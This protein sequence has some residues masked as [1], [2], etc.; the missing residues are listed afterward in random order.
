MSV[1][2]LILCSAIFVGFLGWCSYRAA[3]LRQ[4]AALAILGGGLVATLIEPMLDN[5]GLLWFARDNVGIAFHLFDRYMPVYVVLGYGFFF[6]G[7]AFL[8]YDGLRKGKP[9]RFLWTLYA[10]AWVFDLAIESVGHRAGLYRYY[11]HQPFN[12][13]GVPLWWMFLNPAL[14]V[15]AGLIF[16]RL[17]DRLR[18]VRS[19]LA[20]PLL[21]IVYGAI[22]GGAGW[23]I[24]MALHSTT[25]QAVL[26]GAA[27]ATDAFALLVVWMSIALLLPA[28]APAPTA[29]LV[30]KV[31]SPV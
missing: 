12:L 28:T 24:F 3:R 10:A 4:P 9:A 1:F 7:Q 29:V 22:Y 18:G 30:P 8:A 11:G 19:V 17:G 2:F 14:P 16:F 23:P 31:P 25:N 20:I 6:G 5:L 26:Y 21:P 15:V 27:L 13:W